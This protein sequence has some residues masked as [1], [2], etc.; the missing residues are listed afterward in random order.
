MREGD[1]VVDS[2]AWATVATTGAAAVGAIMA[3]VAVAGASAAGATAA[4]AT[5]A[6]VMAGVIMVGATM[7]G[8]TAAMASPV[9]NGIGHRALATPLTG[10]RGPM[11]SGT[12]AIEGRAMISW[13]HL[14]KVG[15]GAD[16][17]SA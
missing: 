11:D 4:G 13:A 15:N 14:R 17:P 7:V 8:A 16:C 6:G 3:G 2:V 9:T 1:S 12:W 10:R 5:M